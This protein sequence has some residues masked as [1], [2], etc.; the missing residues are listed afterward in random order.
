MILIQA[1]LY[2]VP[3]YNMSMCNISRLELYY[4]YAH[5]LAIISRGHIRN[6]CKSL[7]VIVML[8]TDNIVTDNI[9]K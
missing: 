7:F 8:R 1:A 4:E 3:Q 9:V 2:T 6:C 5:Y